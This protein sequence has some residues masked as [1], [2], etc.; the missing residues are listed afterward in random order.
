MS[1]GEPQAGPSSAFPGPR[2]TGLKHLP[3][4]QT[5]GA[6]RPVTPCTLHV[7]SSTCGSARPQAVRGRATRVQALQEQ[8]H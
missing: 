3:I 4:K 2:L 7:L 8:T 1:V 5:G 6:T